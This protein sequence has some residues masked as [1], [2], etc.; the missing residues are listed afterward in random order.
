MGTWGFGNFEDDTAADFFSIYT[1]ELINEINNVID[2]SEEIEPDEYEGVAL[3]CKVEI[4][5]TLTKQKWVGCT[6]PDIQIVKDWCEKYLTVYDTYYIDTKDNLT[7]I[8]KR[9]ETI[10]NTFD[11]YILAISDTIQ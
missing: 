9:R 11:N 8:Q 6:H 5:T 7:Y 1:S 10:Q 2:K 4:L 3:P